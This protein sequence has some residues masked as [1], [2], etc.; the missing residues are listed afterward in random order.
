[1]LV[2]MKSHEKLTYLTL[3]HL[4]VENVGREKILG[5]ADTSSHFRDRDKGK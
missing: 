3:I 4:F 5:V 1:M 2:E